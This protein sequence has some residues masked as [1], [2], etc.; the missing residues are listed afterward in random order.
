MDAIPLLSQ[1]KSLF[2]AVFFDFEG[3]RRTQE[4]FS[5]QCPVVSQVRS[6]CEWVSGDSEAATET[7]KQCLGFVSDV[8]NGIPAVGHVKGG[9]H[10]L[11]GDKDGGDKAMKSAS[12]TTGVMGG[13]VVGFFVAGPPGAAAGGI[14]GGLAVDGLTTGID[15][16][17]HDEYRPSGM[18][19]QVTEIVKDPKNPGLYFDTL[20]MPVFDAMSGI[21]AGKGALKIANKMKTKRLVYN[22]NKADIVGKVGKPAYKDVSKTTRVARQHMRRGDVKSNVPRVITRAK[23]LK[24][25][26]SYTG[27]NRQLRQNLRKTRGGMSRSQAKKNSFF[28][29]GAKSNV[30]KKVPNARKVLRRDP[31]SCAEH[32]AL[33]K[34]YND[35]PSAKPSEIRTCTVKVNARNG[36]IQALKRCDNCMEY[37]NT[38]GSVP[39]DAISGLTVHEN[40]GYP[41]SKSGGALLIGSAACSAIKQRSKASRRSNDTANRSNKEETKETKKKKVSTKTNENTATI[42]KDVDE[43]AYKDTSKMTNELELGKHLPSGKAVVKSNVPPRQVTS[44]AKELKTKTSYADCNRQNLRKTK[45]GMSSSQAKKNFVFKGNAKSSLQKKVPKYDR[46]IFQ[47]RRFPRK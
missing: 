24:S 23:D 1:T 43:P 6:A 10:Y 20:A 31:R 34:L 46:K 44:R 36:T 17:V 9:I 7:Q 15:S 45:G 41:V 47:P 28:K 5:R 25:K 35:R 19:S 30:Q 12:R 11:C 18:V 38:M 3:A 21:S 2:Q 29:D 22:R 14:A 4:N 33:H 32:H 40:P 16:A 13:G 27:C 42:M 26:K 37:G 8:V 39:T